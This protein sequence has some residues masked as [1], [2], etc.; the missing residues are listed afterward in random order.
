[1]NLT[2]EQRAA[3]AA[4]A[5]QPTEENLWQCVVAFQKVPFRTAS[6]LPFTY[7]LKIGRNGV[8]TRELWVDRREQSKSLAWSSVRLAFD[9]AMEKREEVFPKPKALADLRGI[10]YSF[11]LLWRFGLI[12]VPESVAEKMKAEQE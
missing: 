8:Y 1:M 7:T 10:S 3:L 11:P 5:V 2:E 9:R 12:Q 6:G 4:I